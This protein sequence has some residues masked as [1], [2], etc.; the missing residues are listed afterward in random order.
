[1]GQDSAVPNEIIRQPSGKARAPHVE[2][3]LKARFVKSAPPGRHTDGGGL[4]L[5]VDQ[6]GARR[7]LL[8]IMVHGKRRDFGLGS[9]PVVDLEEAREKA[10]DYR[11]IVKSG[12]NPIVDSQKSAKAHAT[13]EEV[14]KMMHQRQIIPNNRNGKH[15]DQWINTLQKY[16]FPRIGHMAIREISRSDVMDVLEPVWLTKQETARRLYQRLSAVFRYALAKEYRSDGNPVDGLRDALPAQKK[17][18]EHFTAVDWIQVPT[19]FEW[20]EEKDSVS[21]LALRFTIL[22]AVRSGPVRNAVW[23]EFDDSLTFWNIPK[24]KMKS[25]KDFT[26]PLP[27]EATRILEVAKRMPQSPEGFVFPSPTK[28]ERPLSDAAMRKLLQSEFPGLTVHGFRT[29]FRQWT[30]EATDFSREVKEYAL[31]HSIQNKTEAAYRRLDYIEQR[32]EMMAQW[33]STISGSDGG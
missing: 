3:R 32:E 31:A 7:W 13:F 10:I 23:S 6:S 8:R 18:V 9:F 16:A 1:M 22:T 11:R 5:V 12:G 30:E 27:E 25:N 21:S 33:A 29:S 24:G 20:L 15:V 14:A 17:E 2:R 28:P 4:Y 19:I 26:V